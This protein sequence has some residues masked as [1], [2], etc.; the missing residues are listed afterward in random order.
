MKRHSCGRPVL[1]FRTVGQTITDREQA[2][3]YT[4]VYSSRPE[5]NREKRFSDTNRKKV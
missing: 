4:L 1:E 3:E 5:M 2:M